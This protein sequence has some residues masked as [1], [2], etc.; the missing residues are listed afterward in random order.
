MAD[1]YIRLDLVKVDERWRVDGVTSLNFTVD[2]GAVQ[3]PA[4]GA[5]EDGEP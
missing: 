2:E 5:A 1:S 3:P 4:P